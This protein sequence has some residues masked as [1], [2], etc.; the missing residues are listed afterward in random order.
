M[1]QAKRM[2]H[3]VGDLLEADQ[4]TRGEPVLR[5]RSTEIDTLVNRVVTAFPFAEER[6]LDVEL[7]SATIQVD[8][9]RI[10][11]LLDDLLTAAVARTEKGDR[12]ALRL[13]RTAEGVLI[14]VEDGRPGRR[15]RRAGRPRSSPSCTGG[16][17]RGES[18]PDGTGVVRAFLPGAVSAPRP[19]AATTETAAV[20]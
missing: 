6:R 14:S 3:A 2:E 4:L 15:G 9:A 20:S 7:E 11:R 19:D 17:A 12:I 18:L 16:W 8:P 1:T 5:R 13:E 10:E